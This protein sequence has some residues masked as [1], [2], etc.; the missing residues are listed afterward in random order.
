[1]KLA[2]GTA[3]FSGTYSFAKNKDFDK[4]K[5]QQFISYCKKNNIFFLDTASNYKN[6][7][8]LITKTKINLKTKIISKVFIDPK[9]S[10]DQN[11]KIISKQID[12][13][14]GKKLY[15][16]LLHNPEILKLKKGNIFW[17]IMKDVKKKYNI[18]KIGVSVYNKSDL[19]FI[20]KKYKIEIAQF[21]LN[22]FD[23]RFLDF[24]LINKLNKKGILIFIRSVFL[25]G[26]LIDKN[27][28]KPKNLNIFE[29]YFKKIFETADKNNITP[30]SLSINFL[31]KNKKF[32]HYAIIAPDDIDQFIEINNLIKN[33]K[34]YNINYKNFKNNN[35]KLILPYLWK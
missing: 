13:L 28:K 14:K 23:Q 24:S 33:K 5:F 30:L 4:K 10:I 7:H 27:L 25:R 12:L 20:L 2:L 17:E 35:E 11:F 26:F 29:K 19:I 16:L 32:F 18:K 34:N 8:E 21:P 6:V 31:K 3:Q 15:G 9:K 1:M 22:I